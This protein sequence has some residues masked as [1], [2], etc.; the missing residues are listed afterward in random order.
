M[1]YRARVAQETDQHVGLEL[2]ADIKAIFHEKGNPDALPTD[3]IIRGLIAIDDRPWAT[4]TKGDKPITPHRLRLLLKGFNVQKRE[5]MRD[6]EDTFRGY[7]FKAFADAFARY[8]PSEV[9]QVAQ[10][11]KYGPQ[12]AKIE[13]EH[14]DAVPHVKSAISSDKH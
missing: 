11:D 5:K 7:E 14:G 12:L 9:E 8:L 10:R 4:Y 1:G 3:E 2:L 13:V 6:G